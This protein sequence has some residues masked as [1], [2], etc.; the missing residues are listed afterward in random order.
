MLMAASLDLMAEKRNAHASEYGESIK[1]VQFSPDGK[2]IVSCGA[3]KAIKV[4]GALAV[5]A[6]AHPAIPSHPTVL[7]QVPPP[8]L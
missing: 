5:P 7:M 2:T 6:P 3:D 4:W 1:G 8:W